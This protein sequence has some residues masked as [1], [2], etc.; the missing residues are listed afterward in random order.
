MR[1]LRRTKRPPRSLG[2]VVLKRN[3]RVWRAEK[4]QC[5]PAPITYLKSRENL[6]L[7][8]SGRLAAHVFLST[9][10]KNRAD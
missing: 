1:H 2:E 5:R 6:A 9:R 4:G 8:K 10:P 3:A 7:L